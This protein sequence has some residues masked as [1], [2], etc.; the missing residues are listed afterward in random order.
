M[1][2][3]HVQCNVHID[4]TLPI[5][6]I[7]AIYHYSIAQLKF[8]FHFNN[9]AARKNYWDLKKNFKLLNFLHCIPVPLDVSVL[10]S[11]I[12][13]LEKFQLP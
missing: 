7:S 5:I 1:Y 2:N 13:T 8:N 11:L 6:L 9:V 12:E 4:N 3:G 10:L